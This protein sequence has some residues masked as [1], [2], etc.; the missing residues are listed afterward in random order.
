MLKVFEIDIFV[1]R[2]KELTTR[3]IKELNR[4][5]ANPTKWSFKHIQTICLSVFDHFVVLAVKG[6]KRY[7][8]IKYK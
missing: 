7:L 5:S 3:A 4:L 8:H 1:C 6:L 2:V